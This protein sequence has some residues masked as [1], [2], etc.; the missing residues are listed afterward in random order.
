MHQ[1]LINLYLATT[2]TSLTAF[3]ANYIRL[4]RFLKRHGIQSSF[5]IESF[6]YLMICFVPFK[7]ISY[8][9]AYLNGALWTEEEYEEFYQDYL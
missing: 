7:N 3:V 2:I 9:L 4:S 5:S 8:G 1:L 6:T